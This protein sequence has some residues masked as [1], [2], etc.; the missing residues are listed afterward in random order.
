METLFFFHNATLLLFTF[1]QQGLLDIVC[2]HYLSIETLKPTMMHRLRLSA[3]LLVSLVAGVLS[4]Q[5]DPDQFDVSQFADAE[6]LAICRSD[7]L[8][9]DEND[10]MRLDHEEYAAFLQL[11]TGNQMTGDFKDLPLRLSSIFFLS[12]CWCD[13]VD[14]RDNECCLNGNDHIPLDTTQSPLIQPY[15]NFFCTNVQE[16][17]QEEGLSHAMTSQPSAMPT[18]MQT[19]RPSDSPSFVPSDFPSTVPSYAPSDFPSTLP[20]LE[21]TAI[22]SVSPSM[23]PTISPTRFPSIIPTPFPSDLPSTVPSVFPSDL[24]SSTPSAT[25]SEFPSVVPTDSPVAAPTEFPTEAPVELP[26]TNSPT[27]QPPP[28]LCVDFQ[29]K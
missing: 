3:L 24:P 2:H 6:A 19:T 28:T 18:E 17:L 15:L 7:L 9:I 5:R 22:P 21:P 29:C 27:V 23:N 16:G 11:Q 20:T 1:T 13:I 10:D 4:Q 25:P 26:T 14:P 8:E 12:A